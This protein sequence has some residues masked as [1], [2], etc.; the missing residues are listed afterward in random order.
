MVTAKGD[1]FSRAL[2]SRVH[3]WIV[4]MSA[5][6]RRRTHAGGWPPIVSIA[7]HRPAGPAPFRCPGSAG[8]RRDRAQAR[9]L[10]LTRG[11]MA[12]AADRARGPDAPLRDRF[13]R[14]GWN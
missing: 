6:D 2:S 1:T 11:S 14:T 7:Q 4:M 10:R 5:R 8:L 12:G 9:R 3:V 13:V